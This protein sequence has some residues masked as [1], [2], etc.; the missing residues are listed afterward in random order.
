V[1]TDDVAPGNLDFSG[2][3]IRAENYVNICMR[4]AIDPARVPVHVFDTQASEP[5]VL[6]E[7]L[8][9]VAVGQEGFVVFVTQFDVV[10]I[11][12]HDVPEA[13]VPDMEDFDSG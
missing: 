6:V 3:A 12:A 2:V 8:G 10:V 13:F 4:L 1:Q 11:T 9:I 5:T 7:Y